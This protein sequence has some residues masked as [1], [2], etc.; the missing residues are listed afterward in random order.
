MNDLKIHLLKPEAKII[1]QGTDADCMYFL[2]KGECEVF[3]TDENLV[4]KLSA[5]LKGG[6]YF[7][8][9]ALLKNCKRTATVISKNY[10]T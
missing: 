3:V 5:S 6:S 10:S 9:I 1:R 2:A 4:E 8:E 7:G